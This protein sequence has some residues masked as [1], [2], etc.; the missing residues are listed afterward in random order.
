MA[1]KKKLILSHLRVMQGMIWLVEIAA[2]DLDTL[3]PAIEDFV[4][5]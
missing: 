3:V 4:P 2:K 1:E 5:K